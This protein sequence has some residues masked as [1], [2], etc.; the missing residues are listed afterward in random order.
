MKREKYD[1]NS[2]MRARNILKW[3]EKGKI[4]VRNGMFKIMT[5]NCHLRVE[6]KVAP[7]LN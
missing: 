4:T 6:G 3:K 5:K 1:V 7:L 2:P